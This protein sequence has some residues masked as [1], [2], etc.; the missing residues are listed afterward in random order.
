MRLFHRDYI[1]PLPPVSSLVPVRAQDFPDSVDGRVAAAI[2]ALATLATAEDIG[3]PLGPGAGLHEICGWVTELVPDEGEQGQIA[4]WAAQELISGLRSHEVDFSLID[5]VLGLDVLGQRHY[6]LSNG[7]A[8]ANALSSQ[9]VFDALISLVNGSSDE[10]SG[11]RHDPGF[12]LEVFVYCQLA[13]L[14]LR[15][16]GRMWRQPTP[17]GADERQADLADVLGP[18][19]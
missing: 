19:F 15:A 10:L 14:R 6:S 17:Y 11:V 4:E 5:E 9:V 16:A 3:R 18:Q 12:A 7:Q 1:R 13:V 2:S 8:S